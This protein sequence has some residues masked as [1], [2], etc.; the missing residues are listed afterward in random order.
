MLFRS[1]KTHLGNGNIV[2]DLKLG[3]DLARSGT[4]ALFCPDAVVSSTFPGN[5]EGVSSQRTRWEHG[6]L[7]IILHVAPRFMWDAL[8]RRDVKQ[9]ALALDLCVP[10]LS[11]MVLLAL[12]IFACSVIVFLMFGRL[13]ALSISSFVLIAIATSVMAAWIG[14]GKKVITLVDLACVPFYVLWKIP[15]YV[16]FV[17]SRQAEWVRSK[18][19]ESKP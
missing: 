13:T 10:P 3:I 2:E 12:S 5:S 18:R 1:Q 4:P 11:L 15:L 14:Y 8:C 7:G 9:L 19:D 17:F 16:K 6:H